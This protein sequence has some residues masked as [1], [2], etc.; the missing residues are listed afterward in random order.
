MM[1]ISGEYITVQCAGKN[2]KNKND[3][4]AYYLVKGLMLSVLCDLVDWEIAKKIINKTYKNL[5]KD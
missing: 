5:I 1:V 2:L 4:A 3:E